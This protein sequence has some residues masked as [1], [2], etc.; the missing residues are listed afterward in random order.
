MLLQSASVTVAVARELPGHGARPL[1]PV[2]LHETASSCRAAVR[3]Q[4][5]AAGSGAS[6]GGRRRTAL[7]TPQRRSG[8]R[9]LRHRTGSASRARSAR[10]DDRWHS[11]V[12]GGPWRQ[13]GRA[14]RT[15]A[16]RPEGGQPLSLTPLAMGWRLRQSTRDSKEIQAV[17]PHPRAPSSAG[18][19]SCGHGA[20]L[21][22]RAGDKSAR[23]RRRPQGGPASRRDGGSRQSGAAR[24][25]ADH[26][27]DAA[28]RA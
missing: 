7:A 21:A 8:P 28:G 12:P 6:H 2:S 11:R 13:R 17:T 23:P 3:P 15:P 1:G 16:G 22:C 18:G 5:R 9:H 24:T 20:Q 19:P 4:F 25:Q 27:S 26:P 14:G 10:D